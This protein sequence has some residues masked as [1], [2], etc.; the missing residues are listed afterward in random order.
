MSPVDKAWLI[1]F[2]GFC[3]GLGTAIVGDI[4]IAWRTTARQ[5][6]GEFAP[7]RGQPPLRNP[8]PVAFDSDPVRDEHEEAGIG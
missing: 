8:P 1:F 6:L 4:F 5:Y 3:F 7:S 2:G